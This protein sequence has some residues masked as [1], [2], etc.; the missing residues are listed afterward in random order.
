[1]SAN[2]PP[3]ELPTGVLLNRP[4][5]VA[6]YKKYHVYIPKL[7]KTIMRKKK[8]ISMTEGIWKVLQKPKT[9]ETNNLVPLMSQFQNLSPADFLNDVEYEVAKTAF[10]KWDD[11]ELYAEDDVEMVS[12]TPPPP[13]VTRNR[14]SPRRTGNVSNGGSDSSAASSDSETDTKK[15]AN[16]VK[17]TRSKSRSASPTKTAV[18]ENGNRR[19]AES[20]VKVQK[21]DVLNVGSDSSEEEDGVSLSKLKEVASIAPPKRRGRKP[22]KRVPTKAKGSVKRTAQGKKKKEKSIFSDSQSEQTEDSDDSSATELRTKKKQKKKASVSSAD[23]KK[24]MASDIDNAGKGI[25]ST[26]SSSDN[27]EKSDSESDSDSETGKEALKRVSKLDVHIRPPKQWLSDVMN[28]A[29]GEKMLYEGLVNNIPKEYEHCVTKTKTAIE[30]KGG[31][32]TMINN[33]KCELSFKSGKY[34][35]CYMDELGLRLRN[36]TQVTKE[37]GLV[38]QKDAI[39]FAV[40]ATKALKKPAEEIEDD[41]NILR[42]T[43]ITG[44]RK[45][46]YVTHMAGLLPSEKYKVGDIL[47]PTGFQ[48]IRRWVGCSKT[49]PGQL[50]PMDYRIE[51]LAGPVIVLS[52]GEPCV[53]LV[54]HENPFMIWRGIVRDI[55]GYRELPRRFLEVGI[56]FSDIALGRTRRIGQKPPPPP[57][58]AGK[59]ANGDNNLAR[60]DSSPS[61]VSDTS[62]RKRGP[63]SPVVTKEKTAMLAFTGPLPEDVENF[64]IEFTET[65][66]CIGAVVELNSD[67]TFGVVGLNGGDIG[68]K[69]E[70]VRVGDKIVGYK[71]GYSPWEKFDSLEHIE[72]MFKRTDRNEISI[73]VQR[74]K[75]NISHVQKGQNPLELIAMT[76]LCDDTMLAQATEKQKHDAYLLGALMCGF[77]ESTGRVQLLCESSPAAESLTRYNFYMQRPKVE[78]KRFTRQLLSLETSLVAVEKSLKKGGTRGLG[79][80]YIFANR[81]HMKL[82]DLRS[83]RFRTSMRKDDLQEQF[84]AKTQSL[85]PH[86]LYPSSDP[87]EEARREPLRMNI[88][89]LIQMNPAFVVKQVTESF[90]LEP[91]YE[92]VEKRMLREEPGRGPLTDEENCFMIIDVLIGRLELPTWSVKQRGAFKRSV[93]KSDANLAKLLQ[94]ESNEDTLCLREAA[95]NA[96]SLHSRVVGRKLLSLGV[97][98]DGKKKVPHDGGAYSARKEENGTTKRTQ[99]IIRG[100]IRRIVN[101]VVRDH[102]D[103]ERD[104][105]QEVF[106]KKRLYREKL[107]QYQGGS[108]EFHPVE[109]GTLCS[110][111]FR[112]G[113]NWDAVLADETFSKTLRAIHKSPQRLSTAW[114]DLRTVIAVTGHEGVFY[115]LMGFYIKLSPH[116]SKRRKTES[117]KGF[118]ITHSKTQSNQAGL[119]EDLGFVGVGCDD[120]I[121]KKVVG[122]VVMRPSVDGK[123]WSIGLPLSKRN[124]KAGSQVCFM[125]CTLSNSINCSSLKEDVAK[126]QQSWHVFDG[127][128]KPESTVSMKVLKFGEDAELRDKLV[129]RGEVEAAAAKRQTATCLLSQLTPKPNASRAELLTAL[130]AIVQKKNRACKSSN[131]SRNESRC[132]WY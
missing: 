50:E 107:A 87:E 16:A 67:S 64:E 32:P 39:Q 85:V 113:T 34:I 92:S 27:S 106:A 37:L 46:L 9:T 128:W 56:A 60:I 14:R 114:D 115:P 38:D 63:R 126:S 69:N 120:M 29:K 19:I 84:E 21:K 80:R 129:T 94:D 53:E 51:I 48:A 102:R 36:D 66:K 59:A 118:K 97:S 73:L 17:R 98:Y 81:Q 117:V 44:T 75:L 79:R 99:S 93:L 43:L 35:I 52:A 104:R 83:G 109:Y 15:R 112:H 2:D 91:L 127:E 1:M 13:P 5:L 57:P 121:A 3:S 72:R 6:R 12:A 55:V 132:W 89:R 74:P 62:P 110:A 108:V 30:L 42:T 122:Q 77:I 23:E 78:R 100:T 124:K 101:T 31:D 26:S 20:G 103:Y 123:C 68:S 71:K 47:I 105:R 111:V 41:G 65:E 90:T 28:G 11:A 24:S 131:G 119:R 96:T 25:D 22:I 86:I 82:E 58:S 40:D 7:V 18:T 88:A 130:K 8:R 4:C 76:L 10:D 54:R 70:R 61:A 95:F 116:A 33:W 45:E 125:Y 49:D